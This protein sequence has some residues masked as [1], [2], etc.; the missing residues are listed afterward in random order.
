MN[1]G[2]RERAFMESLRRRFSGQRG[3]KS[4]SN[5]RAEIVK[6]VMREQGLSLPAASKFVK[7]NGLY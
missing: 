6:Q 3:G 2:A 4:G 1:S 7:E 5:P